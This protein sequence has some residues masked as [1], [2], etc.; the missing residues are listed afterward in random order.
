MRN[1]PS[2][3]R[4]FPFVHGYSN[5]ESIT[6][7]QP[8]LDIDKTGPRADGPSLPASAEQNDQAKRRRPASTVA[9]E[10]RGEEHQHADH[11]ATAPDGTAPVWGTKAAIEPKVGDWVLV[12]V[13]QNSEKFH[14]VGLVSNVDEYH[15]LSVKMLRP[16]E[17]ELFVWPENEILRDVDYSEVVEIVNNP[18]K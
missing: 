15:D 3:H 2:G 8:L 16:I 12:K 1:S 17:N 4:W 7:E 6:N 11:R 13:S 5:I 9:T 18:K 14:S 10:E